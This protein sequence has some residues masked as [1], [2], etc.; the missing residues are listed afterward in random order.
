MSENAEHRKLPKEVAETIGKT[1]FYYG[2]LNNLPEDKLLAL[3]DAL[4]PYYPPSDEETAAALTL[5]E[6]HLAKAVRELAEKPLNEL[7]D[8]V[9]SG[10]R[11]WSDLVDRWSYERRERV[12]R[13]YAEERYPERRPADLYKEL[14]YQLKSDD[15]RTMIQAMEH[16]V[17]EVIRRNQPGVPNIPPPDVTVS[18]ELVA[19]TKE[20]ADKTQEAL[21]AY[22]D[23]VAK[24]TQCLARCVYRIVAAENI[25]PKKD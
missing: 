2:Q 12:E 8:L 13:R 16:L 24:A 14:H 11:Q 23:R 5:R 4:A 1:V 6:W 20:F 17:E 21:V 18:P 22:V 10:V 15:P 25:I 3:S 9:G 7:R 19:A